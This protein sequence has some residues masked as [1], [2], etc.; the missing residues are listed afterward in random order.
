MQEKTV[1]VCMLQSTVQSKTNTQKA[2]PWYYMGR[3]ISLLK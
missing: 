1:G 2:C 3:I